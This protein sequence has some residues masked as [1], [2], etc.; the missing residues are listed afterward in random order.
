MMPT[1]HELP[2]LACDDIAARALLDMLFPARGRPAGAPGTA[3][4][5]TSGTATRRAPR[6][7]VRSTRALCPD[8]V[9]VIDRPSPG[10]I[11][12]TWSD[13]RFGKHSEQIWHTALSHGPAVCALTAAARSRAAAA[14]SGRAS[15]MPT[16]R[17][18]TRG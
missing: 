12:V 8:H 5:S 3:A 7:N 14:C 10:S 9:A 18:T 15:A 13:P 1:A 4:R 6:A 16:N 11:T 17:P 2:G